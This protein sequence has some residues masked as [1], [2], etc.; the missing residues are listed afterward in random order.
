[1]CEL[2]IES[3]KSLQH[4]YCNVSPRPTPSETSKLVRFLFNTSGITIRFSDSPVIA[5]EIENV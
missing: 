5:T 4:S 2:S 1:M 3:T